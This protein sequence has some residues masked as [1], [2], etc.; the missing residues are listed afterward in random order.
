MPSMQ[1]AS[2]ASETISTMVISTCSC[3]SFVSSFSSW[4][5]LA[6]M[7]TLLS[8]RS[9]MTDSTST[10]SLGTLTERKSVESRWGLKF[11]MRY[12]QHRGF[13]AEDHSGKSG[14]TLRIPCFRQL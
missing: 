4:S 12:E 14:D 2:L 8:I 5:A 9:A 6:E 11:H 10:A 7:L 1:W 13:P 3:V